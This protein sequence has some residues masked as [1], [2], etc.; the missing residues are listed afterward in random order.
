MANDY[1]FTI[2]RHDMYTCIHHQIVYIYKHNIDLLTEHTF[3]INIFDN[4]PQSSWECTNKDVKV[5]EEGHPSSRLMLRDGGNYRYVYLGI[6][7]IPEGIE[8]PT[9][10]SDV[11]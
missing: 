6:S 9:P 2:H 1:F 4:K 8:T 5:K 11:T 10:R 3:I 7:S